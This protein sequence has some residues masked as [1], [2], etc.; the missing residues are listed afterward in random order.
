MALISLALHALALAGS[1][2]PKCAPVPGWQA[3]QRAR[4]M[5]WLIV[6]EVH[7]TTETP[8]IFGD[9][10]CEAS[11]TTSDIVV[12]LEFPADEQAAIDDFITS[13]GSAVALKR[14]LSSPTWQQTEQDGRSSEAMLMLFEKL[15][16]LVHSHRIRQ[17]IGFLP[18]H[19][20]GPQK[21][22]QAMADTVLKSRVDDQTQVIVLVGNLHAQKVARSGFQPMASLFPA[23]RTVTLNSAGNGGVSWECSYSQEGKADCGVTELVK[24]ATVRTKSVYLSNE[25]N[26]SYSGWLDIGTAFTASPPATSLNP[27]SNR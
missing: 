18:T 4:R 6:G 12:A 24:P 17:V 13:D 3:L 25:P 1:P 22:E 16:L 21:H 7:G 27:P 11:K 20:G 9:I 10:V 23:D 5:D 15:R 14:F 26:F 19:A 8:S 2:A